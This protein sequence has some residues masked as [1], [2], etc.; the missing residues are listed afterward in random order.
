MTLQLKLVD[1]GYI[2]EAQDLEDQKIVHCATGKVAAGSKNED[3][4]FILAAEKKDKAY[5]KII[6]KY[7]KLLQ[8][9]P[10]NYYNSTKNTEA[11]RMAIVNSTVAVGANTGIKNCIYCRDALRRVRY[12]YRKLVVTVGKQDIEKLQREKQQKQQAEEKEPTTATSH[13]IFASECREFMKEIFKNDG[14]FIGTLYPVLRSMSDKSYNAF[15]MDVIPVVPPLFRPVNRLRDGIVENP[16]TKSYFSVVQANNQLRYIMAYK[17]ANDGQETML[18]PAMKTDAETIFNLARGE[19]AQE[20]IFY[21]LEELQNAV[22]ITLDKSMSTQRQ[23]SNDLMGLKQLIEKKDG[24]IRKHM[25]GKRVNFAARTVITPDPNINIDQ[26][27][28]PEAFA[29]KL[30]YPVPVTPWN[31][32]ELRKAVING[33]EKHPGACFIE[34]TT[35]SKRAIPKE[36]NKREALANTL[37]TPEKNYGIKIVHR[38]LINGDILLFNRQPTLHRPSIM[39]HKARI[40][41]GEKTFRLHYSNCKSYNA[42]FDGDEM[43][44]HFPQNELGRSEAFNLVNVANNYIVPKDGTPLGGLIQ[45]HMISGVKMSMRGRFFSREDY[46]QLVYQGLSHK[47]GDIKL[48]PPAMLKPFKLWSG[49]QIFSTL[50]LN[51]IPEGKA[52]INLNSTAKIGSNSW[53]TSKHRKWLA[54][55]SKL[56]GNEMTEAEVVIRCGE[57]LCGVLDKN[58]YGPTPYSLV[59]CMYE[60]YG[61]E[62]STQLLTSLA[63]VFTLFLQWE[64]FTLGVHDILVLDG[65]DRK[66]REIVERSRTV[67]K[68]AT[69][70]ALDLPED[71]PDNEVT[72]KMQEAYIKDPKFR[73][74]L[75]RKYKSVMDSFTNDINKTCLPAGLLCKFPENNLQLMVISGA[76]GSTVNTMQISCLLGQIELEGKRPPLMI[77]GKSLPSFPAFEMSPKSGGFIDG[78]FMTGIQPQDFFFHCMAGREGLI[79]TAVKTSRSGYLQRCLIKH[80]EGLSVTYDGTVRDS[81]NSV[82]QFMFGE[83]GMDISKSQFIK[84]KQMT[85]LT[86]NRKAIVNNELLASFR[87]SPEIDEKMHRMMKRIRAYRRKHGNTIQRPMRSENRNIKKCPPTVASQ[88]SPH[89]YFG[90]ISEY[91]EEVLEKYLKDYRY[92]DEEELRELIYV[93]S[94]KSLAEPG[95]AV[96]LLAA[97]SIGEPS[98]QMT[99]NTFHFAGRGDMNVTLGIPRLRE[100]LMMASAHIKTPSMDIPF[101]NQTSDNLEKTAEKFRIRLNQVTLADVIENVKVKTWLR[102]KPNRAKFYE[103]TFNFLPHDAYKNQFMVKPKKII[104]FMHETFFL[105]MFKYIEKASRDSTTFIEK[106]E[107]E[108]KRAKKAKDNDDEEDADSP[109]VGKD[110]ENKDTADA[111]SSDEDDLVSK[112]SKLKRLKF[113]NRFHEITG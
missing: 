107:K 55:G 101:L 39:A 105:K 65:A 62:V 82:V 108:S 2:I 96:G 61:G 36:Q 48:L 87:N 56:N 84:S 43:N 15:F 83:D 46:Q 52:P 94:V 44:A 64:G 26:I 91:A 93:K 95:E 98:T 76:K 109:E 113:I 53:Q 23:Q 32:A 40:L 90:S 31:V 42:D 66:R 57:L 34:S 50:I 6:K 77:S 78:R 49:K 30:T 47:T 9:D 111:D 59:H 85:F 8:N 37:L 89:Q 58:H 29:L 110:V 112:I 71:T 88:F 3:E 104:K 68:I 81:D 10:V 73:T 69:C 106:D 70:Q 60:L 16:Q 80:L 63:K 18:T 1:A 79:D 67:G 22:D 103:F 19:T 21:K 72:K 41:K 33:P 99:L 51:L 102:L 4:S 75:D 11:V 7:T 17:M 38:H 5:N 27:G 45:D 97:Q 14:E 24:L 35:G 13:V 28:V 25:M 12:S 54:G 86:E 92:D 20:K 74:N 100:I